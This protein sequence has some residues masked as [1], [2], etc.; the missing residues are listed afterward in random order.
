MRYSGYDTIMN[1]AEALA[2]SCDCIIIRI[3]I[4]F[5][6]VTELYQARCWIGDHEMEI[7]PHFIYDIYECGEIHKVERTVLI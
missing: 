4:S 5:N 1:L 2:R 7:E 3:D 6:T